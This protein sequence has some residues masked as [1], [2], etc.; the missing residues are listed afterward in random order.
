MIR[1][2]RKVLN[3]QL[4][5]KLV[6]WKNK[7]Y[8]EGGNFLEK[9]IVKNPLYF[10]I[11]K[12]NQFQ[13]NMHEKTCWLKWLRWE[14]IRAK[15]PISAWKTGLD[16]LE[17]QLKLCYRGNFPRL[18][19]WAKLQTAQFHFQLN[20][21]RENFLRRAISASRVLKRLFKLHFRKNGLFRRSLFLKIMELLRNPRL[22]T[23]AISLAL[24]LET[25]WSL[26][27]Y[28]FHL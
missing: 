24:V 1:N 12:S 25:I 7:M 6:R 23:S 15:P 14:R 11:I 28:M 16:I 8:I 20:K 18:Q 10:N 19:T 2:S 17:L 21:A 3:L 22:F 5:Q 13:L 26:F 4:C 27:S 9:I